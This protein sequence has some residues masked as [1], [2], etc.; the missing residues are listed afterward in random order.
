MHYSDTFYLE[1]FVAVVGLVLDLV[2]GQHHD[3]FGELLDGNA[4]RRRF[5]HFGLLDE[6]RFG[7]LRLGHEV[8][9]G[10]GLRLVQGLDSANV[11]RL[12]VGR[13]DGDRDGQAHQD[14]AGGLHRSKFDRKV[15]RFSLTTQ[16]LLIITAPINF[17]KFNE[18]YCSIQHTW[19]EMGHE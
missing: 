14:E 15:E 2:V 17:E 7:A 9:Q 10:L 11:E 8:L 6:F 12:L 19:S 16:A 4:N 3:H 5:A 13:R 1:L 18:G